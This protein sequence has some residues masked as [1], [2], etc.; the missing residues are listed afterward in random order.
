MTEGLLTPGQAGFTSHFPPATLRLGWPWSQ[1]STVTAFG[2][3]QPLLLSALE[4]APPPG[5]LGP[6]SGPHFLFPIPQLCCNQGNA[7]PQRSDWQEPADLGPLGT[8]VMPVLGARPQ[9]GT[10]DRVSVLAQPPWGLVTPWGVTPH[11]PP[12]QTQ[13]MHPHC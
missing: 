8:S 3:A 10:R 4:E 5:S 2:E 11:R 12:H 9:V 7:P 6:A 1:G 13:A